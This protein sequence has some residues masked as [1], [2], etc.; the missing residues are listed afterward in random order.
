MTRFSVTIEHPDL[1]K[2]YEL[3]VE[4]TTERDAKWQATR[5]VVRDTHGRGLG[6]G[7]QHERERGDGALLDAIIPHA[8]VAEV[9]AG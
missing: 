5:N 4:A 3:T 6:A 8:K 2:D 7:L 9:V 1:P